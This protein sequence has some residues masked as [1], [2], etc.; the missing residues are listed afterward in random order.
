MS[1]LSINISAPDLEKL[2][3][4]DPSFIEIRTKAIEQLAISIS[5]KLT[6]ETIEKRISNAINYGSGVKDKVLPLVEKAAQGSKFEVTQ[7]LLKEISERVDD[8]LDEKLS[9][10]TNAYI[11]KYLDE[12]L[13][14]VEA[15]VTSTFWKEF[16][17]L[18]KTVEASSEDIPSQ[19]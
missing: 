10:I 11:D 12:K 16:R 9:K 8:A 2:I 4:D 19:T 13:S 14:T 1:K 6:E 7:K 3:K 5:R 18:S 17:K 15:R